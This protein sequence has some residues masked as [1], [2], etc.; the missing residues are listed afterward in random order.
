MSLS[1]LATVE[2]QLIMHCCDIS[3]LL[4]LARCSR[5]TL[6]AASDCFAWKCAPPL[7][8]QWI[9]LYQ[10]PTYVIVQIFSSLVRLGRISL[11]WHLSPQSLA[12]DDFTQLADLPLVELAFVRSNLIRARHVKWI[13]EG[14]QLCDRKRMLKALHFDFQSIGDEGAAALT[15]L[16]SLCPSL[17]SLDLSSCNIS[18]VGAETLGRA[19]LSLPVLSSLH[20]SRN[21]LGTRGLTTLLPAIQHQLTT[22]GLSECLLTDADF[23]LLLH[24]LLQSDRMR[25]CDCRDNVRVHRELHESFIAELRLKQPLIRVNV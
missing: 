4:A 25:L 7:A 2:L 5:F 24:T 15:E 16:L 1:T 9:M 22:A 12:Q 11:T 13:S 21:P 19:I 10:P 17:L 18:G 23:T 20:L 8:V 6:A 3:S 14:L